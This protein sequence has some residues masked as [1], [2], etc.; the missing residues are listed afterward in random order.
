MPIMKKMSSPPPEP[1]KRVRNSGIAGRTGYKSQV[2]KDPAARKRPITSDIYGEELLKPFK[3]EKE[4]V[5]CFH[6]F[7]KNNLRI[8]M[9]GRFIIERFSVE[10]LETLDD[11]QQILHPASHWNLFY[12]KEPLSNFIAPAL[13]E[14]PNFIYEI[15][16]IN[17]DKFTDFNSVSD[18]SNKVIE[19]VKAEYFEQKQQKILDL[20]EQDRLD[21]EEIEK[22]ENDAENSSC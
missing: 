9:D 21:R 20:Q 3:K 22:E 15:E 13:E 2:K 12:Y 14:F 5:V 16:E 19:L 1:P 11:G 8:S 4:I 7:T 6:P 18:L 10:E 17:C